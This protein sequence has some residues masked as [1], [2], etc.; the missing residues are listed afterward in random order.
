[1]S[2]EFPPQRLRGLIQEQE[3]HEDQREDGNPLAILS[4]A[5][6]I[7]N[8][9][10]V[11]PAP[12]NLHSAILDSTHHNAYSETAPQNPIERARTTTLLFKPLHNELELSSMLSND[13]DSHYKSVFKKALNV[14]QP[15]QQVE[16]TSQNKDVSGN[17]KRSS[18]VL[19]DSF[20]Q[21]EANFER[22]DL[23]LPQE[24]HRKLAC[25]NTLST[26]KRAR[27]QSINHVF[28]HLT[29]DISMSPTVV[30]SSQT[31]HGN[32]IRDLHTEQTPPWKEQFQ[33]LVERRLQR[34]ASYKQCQLLKQRSKALGIKIQKQQK[35]LGKVKSLELKGMVHR[36]GVPGFPKAVGTI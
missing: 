21:S 23:S 6:S 5:A 29:A 24:E 13:V 8:F 26:S 7:F 30:G 33:E 34:W 32:C 20:H 14:L 19:N 25:A 1:M 17:K 31:H 12:K 11:S 18:S 35:V 28:S 9:H 27:T 2:L 15:E 36:L 4:E 3:Q 22:L 10:K 16:E